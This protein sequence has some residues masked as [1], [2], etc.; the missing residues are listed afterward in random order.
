MEV[1]RP[2]TATATFDAHAIDRFLAALA[3]ND[4]R[5]HAMPHRYHCP[6]C[7]A[8][9]NPNVRVVL[10]AHHDGMRGIVLMSSQ[11]G[12]Y[13]VICDMGLCRAIGRGEVVDFHCPVCGESLTSTLYPNFSELVV[14][15]AEHPERGPNLLRFSRVCGE[16]AT[17]L[18]DGATVKEYGEEAARFHGHIEIEGDWSW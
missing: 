9:L 5:L 10:I 1:Q 3:G 16:H 11:L 12:D 17:F 13:Q 6:K 7:H 14:M 4:E 8:L 15:S 18:Y 2:R